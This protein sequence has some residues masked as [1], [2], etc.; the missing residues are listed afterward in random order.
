M[1]NISDT[2]L[3]NNKTTNTITITTNNMKDN[4]SSLDALLKEYEVHEL[5]EHIQKQQRNNNNNDIHMGTTTKTTSA[6]TIAT[7]ME[8][9]EVVSTTD[10]EAVDEGDEDNASIVSDTLS[11][12][13]RDNNIINEKDGL[14]LLTSTSTTI[15]E[16]EREEY[17]KSLDFERYLYIIKYMEYIYIYKF[18]RL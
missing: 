1:T 13:T 6:T 16:A 10:I 8:E 15:L 2:I 12:T 7:N 14:D 3:K 11:L 18:E 9:V 17:L 4:L 5:D